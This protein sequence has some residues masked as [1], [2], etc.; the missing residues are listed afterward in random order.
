M[1]LRTCKECGKEVSSRADKCPNCGAPVKRK[2]IGCCGGILI[3]LF[4]GII[5]SA[6]IPI[7]A[8]KNY[9]EQREVA[10]ARH[11]VATAPEPTPSRSKDMEKTSFDTSPWRDICLGQDNPYCANKGK[12]AYGV[13]KAAK[14]VKIGTIIGVTWKQ[15]GALIGTSGRTSP[16]DAFYYI[17]DDGGGEPILWQCRHIEAR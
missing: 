8:G 1:A 13:L 16:R 11:E 12:N 9:V 7:I 14:G 17:I 10:R 5:A 3:L 15:E 2:G 6:I 4:I